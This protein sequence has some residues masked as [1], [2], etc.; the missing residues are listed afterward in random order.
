[1]VEQEIKSFKITEKAIELFEDKDGKDTAIVIPKWMF[2]QIVEVA[3][4]DVKVQS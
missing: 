1:M 2:N 4:K 3:F